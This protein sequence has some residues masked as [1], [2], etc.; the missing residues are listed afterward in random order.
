MKL[1]VKLQCT[2]NSWF[3]HACKF[4]LSRFASAVAFCGT[5]AQQKYLDS[6]RRNENV[7]SWDCLGACGGGLHSPILMG[8]VDFGWALVKGIWRMWHKGMCTRKTQ[9]GH[10]KG[11][12][13]RSL[14]PFVRLRLLPSTRLLQCVDTERSAAATAFEDHFCLRSSTRRIAQI[15]FSCASLVALWTDHQVKN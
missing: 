1:T 12:R 14:W 2:R 4:Y 10:Y 5:A 11:G 9:R 3:N 13:I 6:R 8:Q 15:I 7:G